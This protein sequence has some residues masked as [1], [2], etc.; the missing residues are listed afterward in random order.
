MTAESAESKEDIIRAQTERVLAE[1]EKWQRIMSLDAE[2][3]LDVYLD[4]K[5]PYAYLAP[6]PSLEVARDYKVRVNFVPYTL[7][8]V[9]FGFS[10]SVEPDM[11]R[12]PASPHAERRARMIYAGVRQYA[13]LQGLPFRGPHRLLDSDL[14]HRAF[15]FAKEQ[16]LEVPFLMTVILQ[17]IRKPPAVLRPL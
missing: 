9:D 16:K 15:L 10:K 1:A 2:T 8:Y 4:L 3:V 7:S 5:S 13:A 11:K 14:A 17:D 6:R 12:R